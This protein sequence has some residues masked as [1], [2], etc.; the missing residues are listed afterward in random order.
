MVLRLLVATSWVE[1]VLAA[2]GVLIPATTPRNWLKSLLS[3]HH[4]SLFQVE[5][6]CREVPQCTIVH[7][8]MP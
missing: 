3:G 7:M 6:P 2:R 1:V 4:L 5:L 8:G